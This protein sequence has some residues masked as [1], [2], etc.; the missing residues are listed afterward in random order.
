MNF[1]SVRD[2]KGSPTAVVLANLDPLIGE[3]T[4]G[5]QDVIPSPPKSKIRVGRCSRKSSRMGTSS[6]RIGFCK[7]PGNFSTN[8][9]SRS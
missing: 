5:L 1:P 7:P 6:R 8:L 4:Q 9:V 2:T 3:K